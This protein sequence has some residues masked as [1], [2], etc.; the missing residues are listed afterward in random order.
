MDRSRGGKRV[1]VIA[2]FQRGNELAAGMLRTA[3]G[4]DGHLAAI[5]ADLRPRFGID[6]G[7]VHRFFAMERMLVIN[8]N[9]GADQFFNGTQIVALRRAAEIP[10][11]AAG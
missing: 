7:G 6:A 9:G 2:A 3:A 4:T 10:A 5:L 11:R 8:R 1:Q